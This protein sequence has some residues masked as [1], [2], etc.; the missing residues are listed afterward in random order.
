MSKNNEVKC[1]NCGKLI[2]I[3]DLIQAG[4]RETVNKE[5]L[6]LEEKHR[7]ELQ[8]VEDE[9]GK[10][11]DKIEKEHKVK[12]QKR[13]EELKKKI[14][15]EHKEAQEVLEKELAEQ[16]KKLSEMSKLKAE[17]SK[18][19]R[20]KQNLEEEFDAK[21]QKKLNENLA[22]EKIKMKQKLQ[23]EHE[24][25]I[26][27]YR[28]QLEDQKLLLEEMKRKHEQGSMQLQGEVQELAIESWLR[29]K[30]PL[31][32]I[33]EI[34]KGDMGADCLQTVHTR[35]R[36]NCGTIYFESKRTK[37]F[38]S[39]WIEKFKNDI[40]EKSADIG[41]LV[42]QAYPDGMDRMGMYDGIYVCTYDEF[43]GLSVILRENIVRV[44]HIMKS[45]EN[46]ADKAALLYNFLTSNEF[47]MQVEGIIQ[48]FRIMKSDLETEKAAILR[49]WKKREKQ[50]E[51]VIS[52]TSEMMGSIQGIS[53]TELES[54]EFLSIPVLEN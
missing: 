26:L 48:A 36:L 16:N 21:Y 14:T 25:E 52:N 51:L 44:S 38:G 12:L 30:F 41:V 11:S 20:E 13:E 15:E 53:N 9:K 18:L 40:K 50:L 6:V 5:L 31:D 33:S 23:S 42:T 22:D 43:K 4:A 28:K 46:R 10:L 32:E 47:K 19:E 27:E 37:K 54:E 29:E 3:E 8:K 35:E 2:D 45:Q 39:T 49:I 17:M 34:G 1:P 7:I 24:L